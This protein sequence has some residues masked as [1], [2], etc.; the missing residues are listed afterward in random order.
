MKKSA[1]SIWKI[2]K[3]F[4]ICTLKINLAFERKS[5]LKEKFLLSSVG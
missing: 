1:N 4:Y 3:Y 2:E 5:K